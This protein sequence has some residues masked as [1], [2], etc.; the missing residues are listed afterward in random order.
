MFYCIGGIGLIINFVH[1]DD[2]LYKAENEN[3]RINYNSSKQF[4]YTFWQHSYD[5]ERWFSN[6]GI[7]LLYI[8]FSVF[9]ADRLCKRELAAD[10]RSRNIK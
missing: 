7:D 6:T 4:R 3:L 1:S 8:S 9:I 10:N 2:D 5:F